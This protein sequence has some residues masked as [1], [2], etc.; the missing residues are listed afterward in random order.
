[1]TGTGT[2]FQNGIIRKET[3]DAFEK[4]TREG[5]D[6]CARVGCPNLIA[7]PASGAACRARRARRTRSPSSTA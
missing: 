1:M 5:I 6:M 7:L 3:H 4:A 2:S